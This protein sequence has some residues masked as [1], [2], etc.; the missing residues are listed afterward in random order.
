MTLSRF[1]K[2]L[3]ASVAF[4]GAAPSFAQLNGP[5]YACLNT[6]L[7]DFDGSV[8]DAAVATPEL[9]TLVTAVTAAGLADTLATAEGI[10]VYAPTDAAFANV[11]TPIL[12][13]LLAD[14]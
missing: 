5:F 7:A 2:S 8:V 9:S 14:T 4:A 13:A 10:T 11:P 6:P 12:D 3:V 1:F